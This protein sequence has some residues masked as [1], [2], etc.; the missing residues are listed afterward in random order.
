[1]PGFF[2]NARYAGEKQYLNKIQPERPN[3]NRKAEDILSFFQE[4]DTA[5]AE[6]QV[7]P[8]IHGKTLQYLVEKKKKTVKTALKNVGC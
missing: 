1:M 7:L 3:F 6:K 4:T 2:A 8:G 5:G